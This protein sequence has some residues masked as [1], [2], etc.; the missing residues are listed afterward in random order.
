[1]S[2]ILWANNA[3]TTITGTIAFN[4]P[5]VTVSAGTGALFPSPGAYQYFLATLSPSTPGAQPPEIVRVTSVSGDVFTVLRGQEGTTAQAWGAGSILQNLITRDTLSV[6]PQMTIYAGNPNGNVA[7]AAASGIAPPSTVWDSTNGLVWICTAS[8]NAATASWAAQAPLNS[9]AFTG[10]PTAPT[11]SPGNDSTRVATTAFIQAALATKANLAG[12]AAQQFSVAAASS[13]SQAVNLSQFTNRS[14]TT[15]G[16]QVLPGG[17]IMQWVA[18]PIDPP[19]PSE[20]SHVLNWSIPFPAACLGTYCS[21]NLP[22]PSVTTDHWYQ[23]AG[24]NTT[25]VT[26]QRQQTGFTGSTFTATTQ[27]YVLGIGF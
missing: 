11:Q 17:L 25:T 24:F 15:N 6:F 1:M 16:Y 22:G 12:S 20:P 19:G 27:A 10:T 8:G 13:N 26:V 14:L 23:T 2:Q 21:T 9:P 5:T 18:G 7:G 4:S 3:S